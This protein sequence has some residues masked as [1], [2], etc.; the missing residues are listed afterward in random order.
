MFDLPAAWRIAHQLYRAL[1][2]RFG[3]P[4]ALMEERLTKR[5]RIALDAWLTSAENTLRQLLLIEAQSRPPQQRKITAPIPPGAR[6]TLPLRIVDLTDI[7]PSA[8]FRLTPPPAYVTLH[9]TPSASHSRA[10]TKQNPTHALA[11]RLAAL[12]A[13]FENPEPHIRRMAR[14]IRRGRLIM[15]IM[16]APR[17]HAPRDFAKSLSAECWRL[18]DAS[19]ADTS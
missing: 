19:S 17:A 12:N 10:R 13:V 6:S 9:E 1:I 4:S 16:L 7:E 11:H 8:P 5:A 3:T 15:R 2:A 18:V 14:A